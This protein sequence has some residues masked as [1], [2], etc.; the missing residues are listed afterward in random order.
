[1]ISIHWGIYIRG[2]RGFYSIT[3]KAMGILYFLKKICQK[4]YVIKNISDK[5]IEIL[6]NMHFYKE[7]LLCE[8]VLI[9]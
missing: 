7:G 4:G 3:D 8:L 2:A 5:V 1:M 9:I 6:F